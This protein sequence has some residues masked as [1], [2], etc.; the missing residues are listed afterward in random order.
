MW[1]TIKDLFTKKP[2]DIY[3]PEP[4]KSYRKKS[5]TTKLTKQM[6]DFTLDMRVSQKDHNEFYG[7]KGDH[8][9]ETTEELCTY[10]N[11]IFGTNFSRTKLSNIWNG[12]V[13]RE[14]LP[15]GIKYTIPF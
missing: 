3:I 11:M 6:H 1:K 8:Q 12:K 13:N 10:L 7:R 15:E 4:S 14:D 9:Y 2:M 5:D